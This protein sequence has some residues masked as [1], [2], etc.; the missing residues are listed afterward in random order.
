MASIMHINF[1]PET[2]GLCKG[3]GEDGTAWHY[4][5]SAC[6]GQGNV[7]V[8][9]PSRKCGLCSGL[10]EDGTAWHHV[11]SACKGSG[12]AYSMNELPSQLA[13]EPSN[14]PVAEPPH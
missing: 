13:M 1:A 7:L 9:Q 14:T 6:K 10:G 3:N 5:C 12:W 2:C 11:C 8:A 4:V